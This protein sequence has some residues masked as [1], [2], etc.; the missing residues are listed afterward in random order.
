M[1]S[2]QFAALAQAAELDA[3]SWLEAHHP[4][5]LNAL[6]QSVALGA[7]PEH[8]RRFMIQYAGEHRAEM[9]KRLELAAV[10]VQRL[11]EENPPTSLFS[12][13]AF[14]ASA[15]SPGRVSH[16]GAPTTLPNIS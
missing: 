3:F 6:E 11:Q 8:I 2:T 10:H 12:A 9:A 13:S 16:T 7:Q 5:Y 15:F 14:S 4:A 1:T